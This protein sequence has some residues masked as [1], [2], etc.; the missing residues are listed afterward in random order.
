[1]I[2]ITNR[3]FEENQELLNLFA[4]FQTLKTKQSQLESMELAQHATM[5]MSTIDEAINS[6]DNIDY[7]IEYLHSIG[8]LHHKVPGFKKEYFWVSALISLLLFIIFISKFLQNYT[9][10]NFLLTTVHPSFFKKFHSTTSHLP[11]SHLPT[12]HLPIS[13]LPISYILI[14]LFIYSLLF[15]YSPFHLL[16][17]H[18]FHHNDK[19]SIKF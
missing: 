16:R 4:K 3:L 8:K 2:F 18:I 1:M 10:K 11:T 19:M 13:H 7:F 9:Y 15:T 5:V 17:H 6:L 12:S 14:L